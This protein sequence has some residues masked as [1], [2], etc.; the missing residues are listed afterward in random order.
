MTAKVIAG[1]WENVSVAAIERH[2]VVVV[3]DEVCRE[4]GWYANLQ[5]ACVPGGGMVCYLRLAVQVA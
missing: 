3:M 1:E 4:Q 2:T 5:R